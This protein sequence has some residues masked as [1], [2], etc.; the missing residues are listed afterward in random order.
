MSTD[1][2]SKTISGL[3]WSSFEKF[4]VKI[5]SFISNIIL[6]RMLSPDD[7]GCVGMLMIFILISMTF[8]DGGFASALIQ[9]KNTTKDDECTVFYWNLAISAVCYLILFVSARGIATFYGIPKLEKVLKVQGLILFTNSIAI[10]QIN[11]LKR[12]LKFKQLTKI[13]I[14]SAILSTALAIW[15]A[16]LG[17]GVWAL[18]LQQLT[19]SIFNA[20]FAWF[21]CKWKPEFRF[22]TKSFKSLFGYGS[23]LLFSNLLNTFCDNLH[24]LI[25]G[26]CYSADSMGFYTQA[27][28]LEEIPTYSISNVVNQVTFPVFSKIQDNK[29]K[30]HNSVRSC[31]RMMNFLNFPL[32]IFLCTVAEPLI[33]LILSD[34]WLPSVPYFQILCVAGV[35]NCAQ[36][37][38]Y[39]VV[40]AAGRSRAIF[41]WNIVK[42]AIGI[43]LLFIGVRFGVEGVLWGMVA[44]LYITYIINAMVAKSTTGYNLG[45]QVLD[46]IPILVCSLAAA[47]VT[48]F[49]CDNTDG[50]ILR[51]VLSS[52]TFLGS[53]MLLSLILNK[54]IVRSYGSI[55]KTKILNIK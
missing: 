34:K 20:I 22:S 13:H 3:I 30:L 45:R 19:H 29:D 12:D 51:L 10:I 1:L 26:K 6:A 9:K 23:F 42:R 55:I 11:K 16:F 27:K 48:K 7:Y 2:K 14:A 38:N 49:V 47:I 32:M 21:T 40:L 39:Q 28:K 50:T 41:Q 35:V 25:I 15:F 33:V 37:V 52:L 44:G 46:M 24:G 8:V 53:Y 17:F 4:G 18:V 36:S 54:D 43:V 31:L 5:I